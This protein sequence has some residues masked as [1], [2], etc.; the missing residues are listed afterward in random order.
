MKKALLWVTVI[1]C[2]VIAGYYFHQSLAYWEA[3]HT[4]EDI[5]SREI[6]FLEKHKSSI[7]CAEL[8]NQPD[9]VYVEELNEVVIVWKM[10]SLKAPINKLVVDHSL[11]IAQESLVNS[12]SNSDA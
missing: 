7:P 9:G 12:C 5:I 1:S 2:S 3:Q 11:F 8:V 10:S 6:A 4:S